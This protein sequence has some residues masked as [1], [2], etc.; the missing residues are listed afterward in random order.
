[1]LAGAA[2]TN[3]TALSPPTDTGDSNTSAG[4][5]TA[6]G[7][8][9]APPSQETPVP[10]QGHGVEVHSP[11][12]GAGHGLAAGGSPA[13]MAQELTPSRGG[14]VTPPGVGPAGPQVAAPG[15]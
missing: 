8:H 5:G 3:G 11:N 12:E 9:L 15:E 14:V 13:L 7:S 10:A 6:A 2:T 4:T 1:M